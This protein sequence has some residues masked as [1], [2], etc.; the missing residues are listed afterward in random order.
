MNIAIVGAGITGIS[1]ALEFARDGHQVTVYE[2]MNAAAEDASFAPG[3]WLLP[4]ATQSLATPGAGMPF[5]QLKSGAGLTQASSMI[6]SPVWRWARQWKK[7]EKNASKHGNNALLTSLSTLSAYSASL[8]WQDCED[9][10]I[11]AERKSG[12]LIML[13]TPQEVAF[14][15]QQLPLLEA[16]NVACKMLPPPQA[17]ALEPGLGQE[18]TW[19]NAVYFPDGESI[20]PRLWAQYLRL[21]AQEMGV[22]IRTGIRIQS[23]SKQP[24]GVEITGTLQRHDVVVICTGTNHRLLQNLQLNLPIMPTW[25]YSVTAPVR[26]GLQAPRSAIMDW[27]QQATISRVGQRVR[28]TAGLELGSSAEAPQHT[29]TL[30]RM[31]RLLNDWFPGGAQLSSPQV[32]VW[33]GSR[34]HLPDGLPLTGPSGHHGIWLNLAHGSHGVSLAAGCARAIADMV[35]DRATAI[36]MQAFH[37]LRF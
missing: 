23:I 17:Q 10:D 11:A 31:Y 35:A 37:P 18:I 7:H 29:H 4:C 16:Q 9:T 3:G 20:N 8:R 12:T 14:W 26:D 34:G 32:Q 25:G 33:R 30:Q 21:Q 28:I 2:Q 13:R 1:T 15:N 5:K 36:D 24:V 6:G 22:A 27:A 19:L